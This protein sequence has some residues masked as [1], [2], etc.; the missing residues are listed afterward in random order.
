MATQPAVLGTA[1][2]NNFR[3]NYL[4][5]D[6]A[7]T[8]PAKIWFILGGVDISAP[9][10]PTRVIYKSVS[11]RDVVFETPNTCQITFYGAA[12]T[13][14][15]RLEVWVDAND[16]TLLFG[17]ELQTVDR[18]YKGRPSTVL[19]PCTAIDDTARANRKRP[20]GLWT[21]TSATTI[22]E[23]LISTYAPGY[24]SAGVEAGLPPVSI[25]F[26]GSE[27]GMK[28][29]LTALAKIIGGYWHF[30]NRT[31]YLFITPPGPAPDPI[32]DSPSRFLHDPQIR[33]TVDKSQVRTRVFG[34]GA[35]TQIAATVDQT[36]TI[37]PL[38]V[39]TM[40]TPAGGQVIAGVTPDGAASRV[41]TYTGVQLGGGG[42][43]VGPG[44]APSSAPTLAL[45]SGAGVNS[46]THGYA[47]T[48][49]TAAGESLPGP[50]A[51]ITVGLVAPP[52]TAPVPG[53]VTA[54]GAIEPGSYTYG[55]T[56]VTASGETDLLAG[57][58][59]A[60]TTADAGGSYVSP[61]TAPS[62]GAPTSGGS[63]GTGSYR[64]AATFVTAS[65]ETTIGAASAAVMVPGVT[66]IV[67]PPAIAPGIAN[68]IDSGFFSQEWAIGDTVRIAIAYVNPNGQTTIGPLSNSVVIV[69]SSSAGGGGPCPISISGMSTSADT[70]VT[71]KRIYIQRNGAFGRYTTCPNS[72]TNIVTYP[73]KSALSGVPSDTNTATIANART[74]TV[75]SVPLGPSGVTARK[76]YRSVNSGYFLLVTTIANN[77]QTTYT[78]TAAGSG[79]QP[80]ASNTAYLPGGAY[81]TVPLTQI[82]IGPAIV[83]ARRLYRWSAALGW[84]ALTTIANNT[85]TTYSD[86]ASNAT[87]GA[88]PG[89]NTATANQVAGTMA[90]G[91]ATVTG[92]KLYRTTANTSPLKFLWHFTDN[93]TTTFLDS[94]PDGSLGA[95]APPAVD[96]SGLT[97]PSGQVPAGST[98]MIVANAAAFADAPGGW[99]VVGN[100][101]Q[102]IRYS[103]KTANSLTG[104]PATGLGALVASVSYNSTVTAS[105]ALVGVGGI[106]ESI[107]RGSPIHV[108]VQRD[109]LAAQAYMVSLDGTGDGIYEHIVSD[110]RR[111]EASLIQV[112][113]AELALYSRPLVTVTYA[114]RDTKT[115]SGKT[116]AIALSTP[117]MTESL[118]IQDVAISEIG[119][120]PT[121]RP[122]YTVTASSVRHSF[123]AILQQ[124]LRK[125][126]A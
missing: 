10:S 7:A 69:A 66:G 115:K 18:T 98:A 102:V 125:A 112:C 4:T 60:T 50:V 91:G 58:G 111:T 1:R 49:T 86:A 74:V 26:D 51:S 92:R 77:T 103:A 81:Q 83:T 35:S 108:W 100:G 8:R 97:Q 106:L 31:L 14:G 24:S 11:I 27:G 21:N 94:A 93:T 99:A 76:L 114:T 126:G 47:I 64:Y 37:V 12:P 42:G 53:A 59:A 107:L 120:A 41:L 67:P 19:H 82:P 33:H 55:A 15:A 20:L 104:I 45:A 6:Q 119:I 63:I 17:G 43:L 57:S 87:L 85:A 78:D 29:C 65:G 2:L 71:D 16:P 89:P 39:A 79:G 25:N 84:R 105:P 116:V 68:Q 109:D 13:L 73:D 48:F 44:A 40:F 22:A 46:G 124:L 121:L 70:S 72:T 38:E 3:L 80:P 113:D 56:F 95:G 30:E 90:T 117:A 23:W 34:K 75:S 52:A 9:T 5:A 36:V 122:K 110:E 62:P 118:T 123:D 101:E 32:D 96:T 54:G 88:A 28:G 61:P